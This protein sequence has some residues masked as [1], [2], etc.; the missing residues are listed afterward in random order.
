MKKKYHYFEEFFFEIVYNNNF[1]AFLYSLCSQMSYSTKF[2]NFLQCVT[3]VNQFDNYDYAS[4]LTKSYAIECQ[5]HL[6]LSGFPANSFCNKFSPAV[7]LTTFI[8]PN[9]DIECTNG[10]ATGSTLSTC[11]CNHGYHGA[12]CSLVC[13]GGTGTASCSGFGTCDQ[14]TGKCTCPT[15]RKGD[16]CSQCATGWYGTEC[17]VVITD[18][19]SASKAT[20]IASHM[21][22]M[23]TADGVNY[24]FTG[25][26]E[27]NLLNFPPRFI[28][29]GKFIKCFDKF[30]CLA[31]VGIRLGVTSSYGN[32]MVKAGSPPQVFPDVYINGQFEPLS[33]PVY[34]SGVTI[35]R[36]SALEVK[37]A[38]TTNGGNIEVFLRGING[39]IQLTASMPTGQRKKSSG[40]LSGVDHSNNNNDQQ[41]IDYIVRSLGYG[42]SKINACSGS[43]VQTPQTTTQSGTIS[44]TSPTPSKMAG[45]EVASLSE[46]QIVEFCDSWKVN[47]SCDSIIY[48]PSDA[49]KNQMMGGTAI[50]LDSSSS[51]TLQFASLGTDITF[52]IFVL[53]TSGGTI[54][55]YAADITFAVYMNSSNY[56]TVSYGN[57]TWETDVQM[58]LNKWNKLVFTYVGA[59][60]EI[61]MY[62]F[63]D[64]NSNIPEI[65]RRVMNLPTNIFTKACTIALGLWQPPLDGQVHTVPPALVGTV[66]NFRIWNIIM[67]N[68]YVTEVWSLNGSVTAN[69]IISSWDF[70]SDIGQ[71]NIRDR[72]KT[73]QI[74]T[75]PLPWHRAV[76]SPSNIPDPVTMTPAPLNAPFREAAQL[77][78]AVQHCDQL[79]NDVNCT[80]LDRATIDFYQ[81][82]CVRDIES[83]KHLNAGLRSLL[84]LSDICKETTSQSTWPGSSLCQDTLIR[85][86]TSCSSSAC[87]FGHTDSNNVCICFTGYSGTNCD[88]SCPSAKGYVCGGQGVCTSSGTCQ[89]SYNWNGDAGCGSCTTG[90]NGP[91]CDL[92][93]STPPLGKKVAAITSVGSILTYDGVFF[94]MVGQSGTLALVN[95]TNLDMKAHMLICGSGTCTDALSITALQTNITVVAPKGDGLPRVYK[96]N[97][98]VVIGNNDVT[99]A[100]G[101]VVSPKSLTQVTITFTESST[102]KLKLNVISESNT[103]SVT[104]NSDQSWCSS[105]A[106]LLGSCD[107]TRTNDLTGVTDQQTARERTKILAE[108]YSLPSS[109]F[110]N[111][112][113]PVFQNSDGGY[114]LRFN[115]NIAT[116]DPLTY[117][118]EAVSGGEFT[119]SFMIKATSYGGTVISYGKDT[120]STVFSVM[121]DAHF[122][123]KCGNIQ[124]VSQVNNVLNQ[125]NQLIITYDKASGKF[126]IYHFNANNQVTY[127]MVN[128]P[129]TGIF[130]KGGKLTLGMDT[131]VPGVATTISGSFNG[132]IDE[133][134][135]WRIRFSH[136][137]VFQ[138]WNLDVNVGRFAPDLA[139]LYKF[140]EGTGCVVH[141]L[142]SGNN[143]HLS[144]APETE[145]MWQATDANMSPIITLDGSMAFTTQVLSKNGGITLPTWGTVLTDTSGSGIVP[146]FGSAGTGVAQG[147]IDA[148][149]LGISKGVSNATEIPSSPAEVL[150]QSRLKVITTAFISSSSPL[151]DKLVEAMIMQ[152]LAPANAI[153]DKDV[154]SGPLAT[155]ISLSDVAGDQTALTETW[156]KITTNVTNKN[157]KCDDNFNQCKFGNLDCSSVPSTCHCKEGYAGALCDQTCPGGVDN[158]CSMH[159]LCNVTAGTCV[160]NDHWSG[161]AC[162]T[163]ATGYTGSDCTVLKQN[164][165]SSNAKKVAQLGGSGSVVTTDMTSFKFTN[166][167]TLK[168][169]SVESEDIKVF[170]DVITNATGEA[171]VQGLIIQ[172]GDKQV[173]IDK[174]A[175]TQDGE[176]S[177]MTDPQTSEKVYTTINLTD[178]GVSVTREPTG[179]SV[180]SIGNSGF[181]TSV[182]V[183]N[184]EMTTTFSVKKN[185]VT[186]GLLGS[187]NTLKAIELLECSIDPCSS[188]VSTNLTCAKNVSAEAVSHYVNAQQNQTLTP[189]F[190]DFKNSSVFANEL[191]S[192]PVTVE[193]STS[194]NTS[195]PMALKLNGVGITTGKMKYAFPEPQFSLQ[196]QV[197]TFAKGGVIF[198]Y[199]PAAL[200]NISG[201][202]Q[203]R[204]STS[205]N[206]IYT[207]ATTSMFELVNGDAGLEVIYKGQTIRTGLD[208][209]N[210]KWSQIDLGFDYNSNNLQVYLTSTQPKGATKLYTVKLDDDAFAPA[211]SELTIG[212]SVPGVQS[213]V[214]STFNGLLNEVRLSSDTLTP[215]GVTDHIGLATSETTPEMIMNWKFTGDKPLTDIIND[216]LFT[217]TSTDVPLVY[218][219]S[220]QILT[221]KEGYTTS[222]ETPAPRPFTIAESYNNAYTLANPNAG[223]SAADLMTD[224]EKRAAERK[225]FA[226][227][228][229]N[230]LFGD[231]N[232]VSK[233]SSTPSILTDNYKK[234]C[235]E[236]VSQ[237]GNS[238]DALPTV[239]SYADLCMKATGTTESPLKNQCNT[240]PGVSFG[241]AGTSCTVACEFGTFSSGQCQ[242][243]G[244][245]SGTNCTVECPATSRGICNGFS[246]C[247]ATG[248]CL[249]PDS[250]QSGSS[251][252]LIDFI[253]A[254]Q[255]TT[256]DTSTNG[257]AS[258][259]SQV[260][261]ASSSY[262]R[263]GCNK[264]NSGHY[265]ADCSVIAVTPGANTGG[266]VTLT[267]RSCILF[268]TTLSTFD[269]LLVDVSSVGPFNIL[270][271]TDSASVTTEIQGLFI[272]VLNSP[273]DRK[274]D[275]VAVRQGSVVI[276]VTVQNQEP[277]V[278][279][280]NGGTP[281]SIT[282][283]YNLA[284]PVASAN[285]LLDWDDTKTVA[286]RSENSTSS[287]NI[288]AAVIGDGLAVF[289]NVPIQYSG[290]LTKMCGDNDGTAL[291][292]ANF[293]RQL[294]NGTYVPV[295]QTEFENEILT[296]EYLS[297][298]YKDFYAVAPAD[299]FID[300]DDEYALQATS[301]GHM[302]KVDGKTVQCSSINAGPFEEF[303][304]TGK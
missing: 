260:T 154:A 153:R 212:Q 95:T 58:I 111:N 251:F 43:S 157:G 264:C 185:E 179:I 270:S 217:A 42:T 259:P 120:P 298:A 21:G 118:L 290:T 252:S 196:L 98:E 292:D 125:W 128:A 82:S 88:V 84:I 250:T 184:G 53:P 273:K 40:L 271:A 19:S 269:G 210:N 66:D 17:N 192:A 198:S 38:I 268:A 76:W 187:C 151:D 186:G 274:L 219:E 242:C 22:S 131:V 47:D 41:K 126:H 28:I 265:G 228:T 255:N 25:V 236:A 52:E 65:H 167:G 79:I 276:T 129:C 63:T 231:S 218:E 121:N 240:F 178:I 297:K 60:G 124:V 223:A 16:D 277:S 106:A 246:S 202:Y 48:Y 26:G 238:A 54:F 152:G 173:Y 50:L 104:I 67:G 302:L 144:C 201:P 204:N 99:P 254:Y 237:T 39:Y 3:S 171:S 284:A 87:K 143:L 115:G 303:T 32:I 286:I 127:D 73:T 112:L 147:A 267:S 8:G 182:S 83:E 175:I 300:T 132:Y 279:V 23:F 80:T 301:A 33:K 234:Q 57:I 281:V 105:N 263:D 214:T 74:T 78:S 272:P 207:G 101:I 165:P 56:V 285:I 158:P 94:K 172:K 117:D 77:K 215:E 160:C 51:Y 200:H 142:R 294:V 68:N 62:I 293:G 170:A 235:Q 275:A 232:L 296:A 304:L 221:V 100:T 27:Y 261:V 283:P 229:C 224:E 123:L 193:G 96:D 85:Q 222:S 287:L 163:C 161:T 113:V 189:L 244:T 209:E 29:Q 227:S 241:A 114:S 205:S 190:R 90:Y 243:D 37:L 1:F 135:I 195:K 188:S 18:V 288:T 2:N 220:T 262:V 225:A 44:V 81:L 164:V 136:D 139:Y 177:I 239:G 266:N 20:V 155:A 169:F 233:C 75:S 11:A 248:E 295:S 206:V 180:A 134:S 150:Q 282:Y 191:P 258:N 299:S 108:G 122:T 86:G 61:N 146:D 5:N 278:T 59:T 208:L 12:T 91:D 141:D 55:S 110:N 45:N 159:G 140:G 203:P 149:G 156:N 230:S 109:S 174:D 6:K 168:V 49:W 30:Y 257:T 7:K 199:G 291:D 71:K 97:V 181:E 13:P 4:G 213:T 166:N 92:L 93:Y 64:T 197:K 280:T 253:N 289:V 14:T 226:E 46:A 183:Y 70:N 72:S 194:T 36:V 35:T 103:L 34:F 15:N 116:S 176:V 162:D 10:Y 245:H 69:T 107:G 130:A 24:I 102:E 89:C 31:M 148:S 249:C 211:N 256:T 138:T 119:L 216:I 137:Q 133:L 145:S 247:T 9:C